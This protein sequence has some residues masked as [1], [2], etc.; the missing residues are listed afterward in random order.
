VHQ[1]GL[2][3]PKK[4]DPIPGPP[5]GPT[6]RFFPDYVL[7]EVIAWY[8]ILAILVVLAS[9]FPAGIEG[10]ANPLETPEGTKPEWYFLAVYEF[11]KVVPR[12]IGIMLPMI[13]L[14]LIAI[15]PFLERSPE[16]LM[17]RRKL[18]VVFATIVLAI[19]IYF[20]GVGLGIFPALPGAAA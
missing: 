17:R 13:G 2:A 4:I 14:A 12:L 20:T 15:W 5:T 10:K 1:L 18:V 3:N 6:R 16:V 11:L 8:F 19:G 9:L 7:D